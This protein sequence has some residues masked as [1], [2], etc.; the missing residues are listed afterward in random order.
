M[1]FFQMH[2][3]FLIINAFFQTSSTSTVHKLYGESV[4]LLK[5]V[6]G[7]FIKPEVVRQHLNDL[8]KIKF[9]DPTTHLPDIELFIGDS[10]TGLALHLNDNEGEILNGFYIG[11]VQFYQRFV[12]KQLQKFDFKSQ[13]T[14]ILSFLDPTKSQGIKQCTF[15]QIE[16]ILPIPLD[17]GTIKLEHCEFVDGDVDS[18]ESDAIK[19]WLDTYNMKSPMGEYKYRNLATCALTLLSIPASNAD[20]KRVFSQVRRIK[21]TFDLLSPQKQYL[22]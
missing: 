11:V 18:T 3:G 17:K 14:R 16:D 7:F 2:W 8:I 13:L 6:F 4:C 12:Q 15:D 22:L 1:F 21:Q 20:C 5:T 10:A 9:H 19:F